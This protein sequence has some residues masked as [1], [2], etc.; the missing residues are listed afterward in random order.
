M[1][2]SPLQFPLSFTEWQSST[3]LSSSPVP[4]APGK[5]HSRHHL[6]KQRFHCSDGKKSGKRGPWGRGEGVWR[7]K[8]KPKKSEMNRGQ[9]KG[10]NLTPQHCS[11]LSWLS[12]LFGTFCGLQEVWRH[13][14]PLPLPLQLP[15]MARRHM[16]K[17]SGI[18]VSPTSTLR[19]QYN[20]RILKG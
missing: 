15:P 18:S 16:G 17:H 20:F 4:I 9:R 1:L 10:Q 14:F 12:R 19:I 11:S 8:K 6:P 13:G 2:C 3:I 7:K 5:C